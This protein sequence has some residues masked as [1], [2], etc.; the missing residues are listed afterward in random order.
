MSYILNKSKYTSK[1]KYKK[2]L[3]IFALDDDGDEEYSVF[4]M[5][6]DSIYLATMYTKNNL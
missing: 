2:K 1:K 4:C 3:V 6:Q 5:F